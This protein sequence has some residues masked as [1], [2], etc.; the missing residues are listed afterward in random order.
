MIFHVNELQWLHID[1][2]HS[3]LTFSGAVKSRLFPRLGMNAYL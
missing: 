3:S 2:T 1:E